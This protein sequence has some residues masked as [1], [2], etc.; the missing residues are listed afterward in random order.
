[1]DS[2]SKGWTDEK[3]TLFL[4]SIESSFVNELH[5]GEYNSKAFLG[6]ISRTNVHKGSRRPYETDL[7][8]DQVV[9]DFIC[10][11][12]HF[13]FMVLLFYAFHPFDKVLC[14]DSAVQGNA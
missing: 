4:N 3:H 12:P 7:K 5:N 13:L 14:F 1:M 9:K 6:W 2:L 10:I 11:Q 8:P